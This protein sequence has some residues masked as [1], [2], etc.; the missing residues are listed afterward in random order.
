MR[1][2]EMGMFALLR[3]GVIVAVVLLLGATG[4]AVGKGHGNGRIPKHFAYAAEIRVIVGYDATFTQDASNDDP[5]GDADGNTVDQQTTSHE[6]EHLDR[7][8]L[9]KHI[10]VPVVP[11]SALGAAARRL[12]LKPTITDP[13]TVQS[14]G[15]TYDLSGTLIGQDS[16]PGTKTRYDCPGTI[17]NPTKLDSVL[18]SAGD[19]FTPED[20]ELPVFSNQIADPLTCAPIS[21]TDIANQLGIDASQAHPGWAEVILHTGLTP[22]FYALR[23]KPQVSWSVPVSGAEPCPDNGATSCRQTVT[24]QAHITMKK[25][26]LYFTKG[27]YAK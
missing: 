20:Y 6:Q 1:R 25:L 4:T 3:G 7:T 10:T 2:G 8:I 18:I 17:T 27:S 13:G 12:A 24:G 9:Y 16:C 19:G 22:R 21:E 15:S 14:D 11:E 5:C 26:F 23:T